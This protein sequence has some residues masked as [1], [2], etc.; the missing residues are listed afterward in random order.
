MRVKKDNVYAHV[1][2]KFVK[3]VLVYA[4]GSNVLFYD[5]AFEN[6]VSTE[7]LADLFLKGITVVTADAYLAALA[8]SEEG[9]TCYDGSSAL[10]FTATAPEAE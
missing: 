10:V 2:E 1:D 9:V 3:T 4:N 5:E 8:Y 7:D 6:A